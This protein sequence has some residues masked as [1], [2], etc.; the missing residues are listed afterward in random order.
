[1]LLQDFIATFPVQERASSDAYTWI[2]R[3]VKELKESLGRPPLC[4]EVGVYCGYTS[5]PAAMA[6]GR[7]ICVDVFD[8]RDNWIRE[9]ASHIGGRTL[10]R[11]LANLFNAGVS[12]RIATIVSES[13]VAAGL[14]PNEIADFIFI[15][16]DHSYDSV[17]ADLHAWTPKLRVGGTL[18]GHDY[19]QRQVAEAVNQ[20]CVSPNWAGVL[21]E[22]DCTWYTYRLV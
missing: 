3:K 14:L 16:A 6:G 17:M 2:Y 7:V 15:D 8:A 1:M 20:F 10:D 13:V 5:I 19:P 9:H 12:N 11:F 18:A 22:V 4:I 21:T